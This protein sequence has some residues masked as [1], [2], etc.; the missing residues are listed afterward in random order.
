MVVVV[1]LFCFFFLQSHPV[2]DSL[3][4]MNNPLQATRVPVE[5]LTVSC[6]AGIALLPHG[7]NH[8]VL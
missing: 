2:R 8:T 7:N 3:K 5:Y 6:Y 4:I 1:F